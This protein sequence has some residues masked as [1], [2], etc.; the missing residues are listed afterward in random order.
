MQVPFKL[1]IIALMIL[2]SQN[3]IAQRPH[4]SRK[5]AMLGLIE[6]N[7]IWTPNLRSK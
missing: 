7:A 4:G 6:I 2:T 5:N 1:L 3:M